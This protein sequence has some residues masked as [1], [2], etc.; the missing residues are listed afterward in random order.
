MNFR[1][2]LTDDTNGD[3]VDADAATAHGD[4]HGGDHLEHFTFEDVLHTLLFLMAVWAAGK[5]DNVLCIRFFFHMPKF[6]HPLA[7]HYAN[8]KQHL[9]PPQNQ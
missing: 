5:V 3:D 4:D 6:S 1:L 2:L 8:D 7:N 9:Q